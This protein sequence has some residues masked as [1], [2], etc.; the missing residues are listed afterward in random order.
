[1]L[2]DTVDMQNDKSHVSPERF[3]A[4]DHDRPTTDELAHLVGCAICRAERN[5]Y[6]N[7]Q[8][9]ASVL[10]GPTAPDA[11]N[12]RR[13]QRDEF[14]SASSR[15]ISPSGK[16][17]RDRRRQPAIRSRSFEARRRSIIAIRAASSRAMAP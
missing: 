11:P 10:S 14:S 1:M 2:A 7:L 4:F 8:T 6:L 17:A 12:S 16:A 5:A 13:R 3:A 9:M 15:S